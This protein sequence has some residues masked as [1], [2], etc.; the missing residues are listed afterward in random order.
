MRNQL[1]N[2]IAAFQVQ[3]S[4][5][6]NLVC[7]SCKNQILGL[8]EVNGR[9]VVF[10]NLVLL[11]IYSYLYNY[12]FYHKCRCSFTTL[13][14]LSHLSIWSNSAQSKNFYKPLV[15]QLPELF[16]KELILTR[17]TQSKKMPIFTS[18]GTWTVE[19]R[20]R[21]RKSTPPKRKTNISTSESKWASTVFTQLTVNYK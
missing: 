20:K 14:A 9:K 4:S 18:L 10:V 11:I 16:T 19:R 12:I 2:V 3:F 21:R 15:L 8:F 6:C 1:L 7:S 5:N 13:M 17:L